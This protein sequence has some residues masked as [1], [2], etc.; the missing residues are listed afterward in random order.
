M[1]NSNFFLGRN[2]KNLPCIELDI[3]VD[4][5]LCFVILYLVAETVLSGYTTRDLPLVRCFVDRY[6]TFI[7][8]NTVCT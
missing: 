5:K 1:G 7:P 8:Y 2:K 3:N 4:V 6:G